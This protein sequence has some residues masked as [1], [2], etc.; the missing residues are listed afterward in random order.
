MAFWLKRLLGA[1]LAL[2]FVLP[3]LADSDPPGRVGRLAWTENQVFFRVDRSDAAMPATINWPVSQGA[4][5]NTDRDAMAE[6][7][8]GSTALRLAGI[9]ELEVLAL[10]D[11]KIDLRLNEGTLA[12]TVLDPE[13]AADLRIG[14]PEG[15][16]RFGAAGRYRI[17]ILNGRSEVTTY[18]G[19]ALI[20]DGE[21]MISLRPGQRAVLDGG[22]YLRVERAYRAD[23]F[24][25]WVAGREALPVGGESRR[26]VSPE[27]PGT[28]DLD[29]HGDWQ[30]DAEYGAVWFPRIVAADWAP[31]RHGRWAWIAPWGWTW[32]DAAPWGFAPFHYGRWAMLGER[33]AWV[34]GQLRGRPVYAPAL[35]GWIGEPGWQ[36]GFSFGSAPAVGW[37]PLAPREV[38][39]PAY[40]HS[41]RHLQQINITTVNN[42][43]V[44]ER[45]LK[46]PPVYRYRERPQALTIV[47][48]RQFSEGR[49]VLERHQGPLPNRSLPAPGARSPADWLRPGREARRPGGELLPSTPTIGH[50]VAQGALPPP[51]QPGR[52]YA[53]VPR[54]GGPE[55]V[56]PEATDRMRPRPEQGRQDMPRGDTRPEVSGPARRDFP[57][58]VAGR[59]PQ[60]PS[61]VPPP[62]ISQPVTPSAVNP[63]NSQKSAARPMSPNPPEPL[64]SIAPPA[65]PRTEGPRGKGSV[66]WPEGGTEAKPEQRQ[67]GGEG[68][69]PV[70]RAMP[71]ADPGSGVPNVAP[72]VRPAGP[73]PVADAPNTPRSVPHMDREI[74][75]EA[76]REEQRDER[77]ERREIWREMP[78]AARP[79][80]EVREQ[81]VVRPSLPAPA[82][83]QS[84][85]AVNPENR[86][87]PAVERPFNPL[88]PMTPPQ[89]PAPQ[90]QVPPA[91][92]P[93]VSPAPMP[94]P[95]LNRPEPPP[96]M[97]APDAGRRQER[98]E[99][100]G[101]GRPSGRDERGPR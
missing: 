30:S 47:P 65:P 54:S 78:P 22:G 35:V 57:R 19:Q 98:R 34:P 55:V 38:Y 69:R 62:S 86:P 92:L 43:T 88:P 58:E 25:D 14:T 79:A 73:P 66:R 51:A 3:A 71:P 76:R 95:Q 2:V 28:D 85:P 64:P 97:G 70:S 5:F 96:A 18:A 16:V 99:D 32:I 50:T 48:T 39:V 68:R 67:E 44:I 23:R 4:L 89:A 74:R 46:A 53:D 90:I 20:E 75:R 10:D 60:T 33:W 6:I 12:V 49:P 63:E 56:R 40:R 9:S 93:R 29:R 91:P 11:D 87:K 7:R 101:E 42:V 31:Y 15:A 36:V 100:R 45:S 80:P 94:A 37:F 81:P 61:P 1:L 21:R 17:D 41:H 8:I 82:I 52:P 27:I 84:T 59:P 13:Q 77:R 72:V 26:H 24:D 83:P